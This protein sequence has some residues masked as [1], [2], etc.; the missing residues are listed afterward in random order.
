MSAIEKNWYVDEGAIEHIVHDN[1]RHGRICLDATPQGQLVTAS[2]A[3]KVS[4][5]CVIAV[6]DNYG[7]LPRFIGTGDEIRGLFSAMRILA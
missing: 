1:S 3:G 7:Q 6:G 5:H 4:V 2:G